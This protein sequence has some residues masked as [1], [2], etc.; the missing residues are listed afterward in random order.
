VTGR[1]KLV[2]TLESGLRTGGWMLLGRRAAP[3]GLEE[4][5]GAGARKPV[6]A[7]GWRREMAAGMWE[8]EET[9]NLIL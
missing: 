3:G 2:R 8:E 5:P 9:L 1:E 6:V 7:G 4:P